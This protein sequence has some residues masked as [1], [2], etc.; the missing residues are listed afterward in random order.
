MYVQQLKERADADQQKAVEREDRGV[1]RRIKA[2][3][4]DYGPERS[5]ER[6]AARQEE[7][8]AAN[9]DATTNSAATG[10]QSV[11]QGHFVVTDCRKFFFPFFSLYESRSTMYVKYRNT[12]SA[13]S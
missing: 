7:Q 1:R 13:T 9:G 6:L 2:I 3:L 5:A 10:G 8:R 12:G 4:T 11:S